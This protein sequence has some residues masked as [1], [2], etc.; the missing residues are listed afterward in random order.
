LRCSQRKGQGQERDREDTAG[1]RNT[2]DDA[3]RCI[4]E[5]G[6]E[7]RQTRGL[8]FHARIWHVK[9]VYSEAAR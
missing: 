4:K 2:F 8:V 7:K 3:G 9:E 1:R 6:E 5:E